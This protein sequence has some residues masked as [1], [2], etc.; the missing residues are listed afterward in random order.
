M[1]KPTVRRLQEQEMQRMRWAPWSTPGA[2][3]LIFLDWV[4]AGNVKERLHN[5]QAGA[6]S[7]QHLIGF[8]KFCAQRNARSAVSKPAAGNK[9]LF[10]QHLERNNWKLNWILVTSYPSGKLQELRGIRVNK[11]NH[12]SLSP[13]QSGKIT[14]DS[15]NRSEIECK[16]V[17]FNTARHHGLLCDNG[18]E[19]SRLPPNCS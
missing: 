2:L 11:Q 15:N 10:Y 1:R 8:F 3:Y 14:P 13:I 7:S 12:L 9:V 5:I 18:K 6:D 19:K 17:S 4:M 16:V